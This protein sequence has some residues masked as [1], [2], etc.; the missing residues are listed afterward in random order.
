MESVMNFINQAVSFVTSHLSYE[1][2]IYIA[3]AILLLILIWI[4]SRTIRSRKANKRINDLELEVNE[5]RN[6]SLQYK[7]NK[8][9]AFARVNDDIMERVKNLAPK[10]DSC[11]ESVVDC[12]TLFTEADDYLDSHRIKKAMRS[13]DELEMILDETKERVRIVTQSLDHILKRETEVREQANALKERYGN[14]KKVYNDNRS[15]FYGSANYIDRVLS[16]IEDEF[17]N[18]EEWMF[19]SEFNKAKEE[20]EKISKMVDIISSQIAAC[21]G[22][23]RKSVV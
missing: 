7:Y 8:A 20:Q 16:S 19:A 9:T 17:S 1:I 13:M 22:L 14:V 3:I 15:K 2:L 4:I 6:N 23:D 12:E 5:I 11:L 21:P 18:F 10:Y